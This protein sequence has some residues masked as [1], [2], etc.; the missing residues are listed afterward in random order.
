MTA[1][2]RRGRKNPDLLVKKEEVPAPGPGGRVVYVCGIRPLRVGELLLT[3]GVEVPG[4]AEWPRVDTWVSTRKIK[5]ITSNDEFI[6]YDDFKAWKESES[7]M[8]LE[9][10][11]AQSEVEKLETEIETEPTEE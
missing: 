7:E 10:F 11:L 5:A 8:S 1:G 2:A 3:A 6:A 4:A 9:D